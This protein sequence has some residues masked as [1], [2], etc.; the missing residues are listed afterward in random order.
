MKLANEAVATT[1]QGGAGFR[2]SC[3]FGEIGACVDAGNASQVAVS[4]RG[5][6]G[7]SIDHEAQQQQRKHACE[8]AAR[9][10]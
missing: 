5:L 10:D 8:R 1:K 9:P 6:D 4:V 2:F 7:R 3:G